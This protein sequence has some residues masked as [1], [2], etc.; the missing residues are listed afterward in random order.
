M[1]CPLVA[2]SA[3]MQSLCAPF[4]K[5]A[6]RCRLRRVIDQLVHY[7]GLHSLRLCSVELGRPFCHVHGR[8]HL[9]IAETRDGV[10]TV[11]VYHLP[12]QRRLKAL[13]CSSVQSKQVLP[14]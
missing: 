8:K 4:E 6:R 12:T 5:R 9:A 10:A 11:S 13:T 3:C 1:E 7:S 2:M 14:R